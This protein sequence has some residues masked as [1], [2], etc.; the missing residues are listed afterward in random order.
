VEEIF[1][2]LGSQLA[3]SRNNGESCGTEGF[4]YGDAEHTEDIKRKEGM[5]RV[6]MLYLYIHGSVC[7]WR[8]VGTLY[9]PTN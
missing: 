2:L 3:L 1:I 5:S 7:I 6:Y 9:K 4:I 8:V